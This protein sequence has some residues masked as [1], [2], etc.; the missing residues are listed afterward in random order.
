[1]QVPYTVDHVG[2][3]LRPTRIKQARHDFQQGLITK[4]ALRQ[5]EDEEIL[6]LVE[7]QK[8]VGIFSQIAMRGRHYLFLIFGLVLED[9]RP[10]LDT[11]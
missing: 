2:S 6:K 1:M 4:E 11:S 5:I 10:H 7:E 8:Q 9:L 3:F